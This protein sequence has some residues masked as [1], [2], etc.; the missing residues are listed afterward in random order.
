MPGLPGVTLLAIAVDDASPRE[1]V[2]RQLDADAV[3]GRDADEVAPHA[4]RCV[5]DEL[6]PV[7]ELDLEHR[8]RQSLGDDGVHHARPL[9]LIAVVAIRFA[10]FRRS[11]TSTRTFRLPQDS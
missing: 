10:H 7:L 11:R 9:L 2:R 5:G 1:V 4:T 8:V 6:V 3:A